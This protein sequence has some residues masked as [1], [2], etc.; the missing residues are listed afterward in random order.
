MG[1]PNHIPPVAPL[2]PSPQVVNLSPPV[3]HM[4]PMPQTGLS[5]GMGDVKM[6]GDRREGVENT[7]AKSVENNAAAAVNG[8]MNGAGSVEQK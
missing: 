8:T 1:T 2:S 4:P 6:D 3:K 7:Q 5:F